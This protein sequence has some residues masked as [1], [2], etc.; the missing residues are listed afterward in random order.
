VAV[1]GLA[2]SAAEAPVASLADAP[3]VALAGVAVQVARLARAEESRAGVLTVWAVDVP[4]AESTTS[5]TYLP[6]VN[7]VIAAGTL[8]QGARASPREQDRHESAETTKAEEQ[9]PPS[10]DAGPSGPLENQGLGSSG[11]S[12]GGVAGSASSRYFAIATAP[13]R[14]DFPATFAHVLVPS[15][16][17][18]GALEAAPTTRP[19]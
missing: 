5:L 2:E 11:G 4:A 7:G 15:R 14:F 13:L 8:I 12:A 18:A 10:A 16:V 17:P 3:A 9:E 6:T 1:A 19:G